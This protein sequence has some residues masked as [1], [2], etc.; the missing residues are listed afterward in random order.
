MLFLH[1]YFQQVIRID[2][3]CRF[4]D[5][6]DKA[7]LGMKIIPRVFVEEIQNI[8]LSQIVGHFNFFQDDLP[9][10]EAFEAELLQWKVILFTR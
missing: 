7:M 4:T 1:D 5:I 10:P 2:F 9:I 8:D 6:Q 3:S